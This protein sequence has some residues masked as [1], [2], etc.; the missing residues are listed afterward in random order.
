MPPTRVAEMLYRTAESMD[1]AV[2]R[3]TLTTAI[4]VAKEAT[5]PKDATFFSSNPPPSEPARV[6]RRLSTWSKIPVRSRTVH[7]TIAA[8]TVTIPNATD[9]RNAIFST[10]HGSTLLISSLAR[11]TF[12]FG[13]GFTRPGVPWPEA[14]CAGR[15][16]VCAGRWPGWP[17]KGRWPGCAG[18]SPC[19]GRWP[20]TAGRWPGAPV[21]AEGR[22]CG[23]TGAFTRGA[24]E[25][26]FPSGTVLFGLG[27][28]SELLTRY[29]RV[30]FVRLSVARGVL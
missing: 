27:N 30:V 12:A 11:R 9:S 18:R 23:R 3:T 10:D 17:W 28:E 7:R 2:S 21:G 25:G 19:W 14:P 6:P 13:A 5:W 8:T 29:L 15:W 22:C 1:S 24:A 20:G 26:R 16:P 4:M